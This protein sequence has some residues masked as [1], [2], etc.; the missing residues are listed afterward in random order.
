[1]STE[2][3]KAL[4]HRF[5]EEVFNKRNLAAMDEFIAPDQVDHTLPAFLP[6]TPEGT[7]RAIGMYLKAFPDLHL[8]VEDMFAERDKVVTRFTSRGTQKGAFVGMPPTGKQ[9]TVSSIVIARIAEGKIVEQWGLD[10]QM[11]MLQQLG[12][13]PAL[14][15]FVLLAGLAAGMGL[16]VLLRKVL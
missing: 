15:G 14:F 1:M 8:T 3:N 9:V 16:L 5:L 7:K 4:M 11:G 10:D 12:V 6:T 2:D 13:I